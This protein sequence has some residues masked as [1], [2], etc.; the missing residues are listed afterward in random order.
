MVGINPSITHREVQVKLHALLDSVTPSPRRPRD[1]S[2]TDGRQHASP[3]FASPIPGTEA[4][5]G[6]T[7]LKA[8]F[9]DIIRDTSSTAL[10]VPGLSA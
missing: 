2:N 9:M 3:L 5:I 7:G 10:K 8:C 4:V 6:V 1:P